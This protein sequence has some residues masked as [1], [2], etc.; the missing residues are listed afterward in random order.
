MPQTEYFTRKEKKGNL[1]LTFPDAGKF[2][3]MVLASDEGLP[4]VP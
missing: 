1:P 4:D 3:S 2:K